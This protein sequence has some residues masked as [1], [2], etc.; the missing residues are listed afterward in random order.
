VDEDWFLLPWIAISFLFLNATDKDGAKLIEGAMLQEGAIVEPDTTMA[1]ETVKGGAEG[2]MAAPAQCG[3]CGTACDGD[4]VMA[5][6]KDGHA[7]CE[8]AVTAS[9][10]VAD[11]KCGGCG[12]GCGGGCSGSVVTVSSK[13]GLVS[14]GV[15][16][17]GGNG[18]LE[19]AG[20]GSGCGSSCGSNMVI[21]R[22]MTQGNTKSGG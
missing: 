7:S 18:R 3:T 17:G 1:S 8:G 6:D 12:S 14:S 16:A 22:S 2:A 9:G 10:K 19:S 4:L 21:E 13:G 20:C 15:I 5:S 11:S